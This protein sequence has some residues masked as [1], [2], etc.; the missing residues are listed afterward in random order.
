MSASSTNE[1]D[2]IKAPILASAP[3][4]DA[5]A[6]RSGRVIRS[7]LGVVDGP[8]GRSVEESAWWELD[9]RGVVVRTG[10]GSAPTMDA[11]QRPLMV[12]DLGPCMVL[13]GLI[14]GHSHAFQRLIRGQTHRRAA[15]DPSDFWSW[16]SAMYEAANRLD[17]EQVQS[18]AR[19]TFAEMLRSGITTVAEF[20]YLHHQPGGAPY[21]RPEELSLRI[22]AAAREVGIR[23]CLLEVYYA[24]QGAGAGPL[25]EQRRFCDRDMAGYRERL[26]ALMPL[27]NGEDLTIGVAPHS[28]RAVARDDLEQLVALAEEHDLVLHSHVSEQVRENHEC[29]REHGMTPLELFGAVGATRRPRAMTAVHAIHLSDSDYEIV[30]DQIVCACPTT[31]ADLGDGVVAA[32]RLRRGGTRI[33]LGSDSNSVIDL[34]TE[35]RC[36]EMHERL[37]RQARLQNLHEDGRVATSLLDAL[38]I[39]GARSVGRDELGRL[40][41]GSPFDAVVIDL[42]HPSML[43]VP[44]PFALDALLLAGGAASASQTWVGGQRLV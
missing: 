35:A 37:V 11:G 7:Q 9:G 4:M 38:T 23:L 15:T 2:P 34:I 30:A 16:R 17:P 42:L 8:L 1:P 13:P 39:D 40:A 27:S 33:S 22:I 43:G 14:N 36:L 44:A 3:S 29:A 19:D 25:P 41:V 10:S 24:R 5:S 32:S 28:V 31:E 26:G 20:H 6:G 12:I 21:E 18:S